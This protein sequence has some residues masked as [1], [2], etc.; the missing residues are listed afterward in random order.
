[1]NSCDDKDDINCLPHIQERLQSQIKFRLSEKV[2]LLDDEI[3]R[4]KQTLKQIIEASENKKSIFQN[5]IQLLMDQ[6]HQLEMRI[7]SMNSQKDFQLFQKLQN[8]RELYN[9]QVQKLREEHNSQITKIKK[10]I[11]DQRS[12]SCQYDDSQRYVLI[13]NDNEL[14]EQTEIHID[15]SSMISDQLEYQKK[16]QA[17]NLHCKELCE[18]TKRLEK[19]ISIRKWEIKKA[20]TLKNT[21]QNLSLKP[22]QIQRQRNVVIKETK[23]RQK[24][25]SDIQVLKNCIYSLKEKIKSKNKK[26]EK[27]KL[28]INSEKEEFQSKI[29]EI[30]TQ[31]KDLYNEYQMNQ[32]QN[33]YDLQLIEEEYNK[34]I[35][36]CQSTQA[37]I[38][39]DD[40]ALNELRLINLDLSRELGKL[41]HQ[42]KETVVS[43]IDFES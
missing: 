19:T 4:L 41:H 6:K 33:P 14:S 34:I 37:K 35:K 39:E 12:N 8:E 18:K 22:K 32:N 42:K 30:E 2:H 3:E 21:N 20:R 40:F 13:K 5:N 26:I 38:D 15:T 7:F 9:E 24:L 23:E 31:H 25:A 27:F 28:R 10:R 43:A 16:I 29:G 36:H 11:I 1:M 17:I